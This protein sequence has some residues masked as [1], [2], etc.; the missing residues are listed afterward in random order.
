MRAGDDCG[1]FHVVLGAPRELLAMGEIPA[2]STEVPRGH[3]TGNASK[4]G[5]R[6]LAGQFFGEKG[7]LRKVKVSA[8][9]QVGKDVGRGA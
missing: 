7:L 4:K 8:T 2:V 5:V 9:V 6:L 3:G 1:R